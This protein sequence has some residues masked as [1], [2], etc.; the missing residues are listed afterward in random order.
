[1]P[2]AEEPAENRLTEDNVAEEVLAID[3][4]EDVDSADSSPA[5]DAG[6]AAD[7]SGSP[8]EENA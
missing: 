3:D 4:T 8:E 1:M 7:A 2:V 6:E 5:E